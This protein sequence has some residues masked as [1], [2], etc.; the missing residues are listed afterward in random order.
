MVPCGTEEPVMQ[1]APQ[2]VQKQ[3]GGKEWQKKGGASRKQRKRIL[4]FKSCQLRQR[5]RLQVTF[6]LFSASGIR[7]SMSV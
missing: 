1:A 6:V 2:V 7:Q 3:E 4:S 5:S